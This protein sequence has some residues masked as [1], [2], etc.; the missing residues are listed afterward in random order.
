MLPDFDGNAS[1]K[2]LARAFDDHLKYVSGQAK[3]QVG[4][5]TVL[6]RP[7]E[8]VAWA[9]DSNPPCSEIQQ[10]ANHWFAYSPGIKH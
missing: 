5:S 3:D 7:D 4:L 9:S 8:I 2:M 1:L 6:I 10:A